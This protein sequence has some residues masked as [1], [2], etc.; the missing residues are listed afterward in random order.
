[1]KKLASTLPNMLLSLGVI[2]IGSGAIL[3]GMY[4]LTEA[5]IARQ[6]Q[7]AQL[8]AIREV[9]PAFDNNP[10]AEA[11]TVVVSDRPCVVYPAR[12]N[13]KLV[14]AAVKAYTMEGFAGEVSVMAGFSADGSV[15]DYRVL[16]QGETPGL[17][18]KMETWFRDPTAARSVIGKNPAVTNFTVSKDGGDIDGIT[19]A[20]ISSRAFLSVLRDAYDAYATTADLRHIDGHSGASPQKERAGASSHK[21]KPGAEADNNDK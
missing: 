19:A 20:T 4:K 5:P 17:G 15:R 14:G 16:R 21:D 6:A 7:E 10:E 2:T 12:M 13:G 9:A 8:A 18:T 3:G 1:M 11:D